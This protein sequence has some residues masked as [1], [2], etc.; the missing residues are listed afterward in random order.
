MDS[1]NGHICEAYELFNEQ[2]FTQYVFTNGDCSNAVISTADLLIE[3]LDNRLLKSRKH[4]IF[5]NIRPA[6]PEFGDKVLVYPIDNKD[7]PKITPLE[8]KEI[9]TNEN[10]RHPV[11]W[12]FKGDQMI[13]SSTFKKSKTFRNLIDYASS[14]YGIVKLFDKSKD[15]R[16][17]QKGDFGVYI[18]TAGKEIIETYKKL[19][20]EFI[21]F[22]LDY[23]VPKEYK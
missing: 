10:L 14:K 13:D 20:K 18:N 9:N 5:D 1:Y 19:G 22:D 7:L 6:L 21:P 17:V 2:G 4:L 15:I 11:F 8:K 3:L 16:Y 12:V 23:L